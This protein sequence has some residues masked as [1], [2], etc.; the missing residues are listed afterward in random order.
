MKLNPQAFARKFGEEMRLINHWTIWLELLFGLMVTIWTLLSQKVLQKTIEMERE[1]T[2][3]KFS[4]CAA[5][6]M[7][8]SVS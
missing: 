8:K 4:M 1:Y 2:T 6:D 7:Y 3:E 5:E